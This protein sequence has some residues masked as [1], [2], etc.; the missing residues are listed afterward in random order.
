MHLF[1][2]IFNWLNPDHFQAFEWFHLMWLGIMALGIVF[3]CLFLK[4]TTDKQ[5]KYIIFGVGCVLVFFELIKQ[6]MWSFSPESGWGYYWSG[7]PW[8]LCSIPMFLCMFVPF[9]KEGK[10]KNACYLCFYGIVWIA[11]RIGNHGLSCAYVCHLVC[12]N[13]Y[14]NNGASCGDCASRSVFDCARKN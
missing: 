3:I 9:L 4:N 14:S 5:H 6:F 11:R 2:F 7:F 13:R 10:V 12:H 8:H 1:G